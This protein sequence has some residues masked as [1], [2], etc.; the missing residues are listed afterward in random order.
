MINELLK[1]YTVEA[2][3][4]GTYWLH[5]DVV[6]GSNTGYYP[7]DLAVAI[8]HNNPA[9]ISTYDGHSV[10]LQIINKE[11]NVTFVI[12]IGGSGITF[13]LNVA[14]GGPIITI[15]NR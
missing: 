12:Q 3:S 7:N 15:K 4:D 6:Q 11:I 8:Q 2:K 13:P 1:S 5:Y 14:D 9:G 10:Q